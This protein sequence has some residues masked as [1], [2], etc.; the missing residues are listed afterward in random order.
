MTDNLNEKLECESGK[1]NPPMCTNAQVSPEIEATE[2]AGLCT[3]AQAPPATEPTECAGLHTNVHECAGIR[4][5]NQI[6]KT[7]PPMGPENAGPERLL[8]YPQLA[9]ARLIVGGLRAASV[10][11]QMGLDPHTVG[12]WKR[13]PAFAVELERLRASVD[14]SVGQTLKPKREPPPVAKRPGRERPKVREMDDREFDEMY[15]KVMR[16]VREK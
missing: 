13:L 16:T 4:V 14:A 9:A 12:R 1:T 15:E 8:S 6:D 7:N 2:C 10:A 11:R 5:E 3:N